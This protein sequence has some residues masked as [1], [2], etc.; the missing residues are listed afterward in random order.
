MAEQRESAAEVGLEA[1]PVSEQGVRTIELVRLGLL[2][3]RAHAKKPGTQDEVESK[4]PENVSHSV[5]TFPGEKA[6]TIQD[7]VTGLHTLTLSCS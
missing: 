4:C 3:S 2:P 6:S 7:A 1:G 5:R